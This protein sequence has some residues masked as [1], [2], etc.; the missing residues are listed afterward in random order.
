MH[1]DKKK[2][3]YINVTTYLITA[4]TDFKVSINMKGGKI[5]SGEISEFNRVILVLFSFYDVM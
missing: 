3:I 1:I 4:V 2:Y 5:F